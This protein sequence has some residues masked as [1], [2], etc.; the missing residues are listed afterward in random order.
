MY[1]G[2]VKALELGQPATCPPMV[3]LGISLTAI[4]AN[5]RSPSEPTQTSNCNTGQ[6]SLQTKLRAPWCAFSVLMLPLCV[7]M[8]QDGACLIVLVSVPYCHTNLWLVPFRNLTELNSVLSGYL[9][10]NCETFFFKMFWCC[11]PSRLCMN[12]SKQLRHHPERL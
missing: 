3:S 8:V 4:Q 1:G 5:G 11:S 12:G 10:A 7:M 6:N 9:Q 2:A